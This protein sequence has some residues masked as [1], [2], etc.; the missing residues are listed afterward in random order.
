V[1]GGASLTLKLIVATDVDTVP[2]SGGPSVN[3][4]P[5]LVR[6]TVKVRLAEAVLPTLSVATKS[7]V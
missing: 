5:G 3:V 4:R 7:T 1:V 2:P 6:S